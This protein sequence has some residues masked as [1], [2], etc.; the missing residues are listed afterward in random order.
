MVVY[1]YIYC[2]IFS[3]LVYDCGCEIISV[4]VYDWNCEIFTVLVDDSKM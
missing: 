2:E 4:V 1:D 3:V